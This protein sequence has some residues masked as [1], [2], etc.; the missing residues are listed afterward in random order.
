MKRILSALAAVGCLAIPTFAQNV[1][2]ARAG[3]VN[4]SEGAVTLRD[5][6]VHLT[7]KQTYIEM[8]DNEVIRTTRGRTEVLLS[9]GVTMRL[10]EESAVRLVSGSLTDTRVEVLEGDVFVEASE[11]FEGSRV[12]VALG[13]RE[14]DIAKVGLYRFNSDPA[15]IRVYDGRIELPSANPD[16]PTV[17]KKGSVVSMSNGLVARK[18]DPDEGDAFYRWASRRSGYIAMANISAAKMV[19]DDHYSSSFYGPGLLG[20]GFYGSG[21]YGT[22]LYGSGLYG[23]GIRSGWFYNPYF[24]MF[25]Y[26]PFGNSMYSPF[27]YRYYTPR[28][29]SVVYAPPPS[30]NGG[31]A[32]PSMG[33]FDRTPTYNPNY[34]YNT[35]GARSAGSSVG[36]APGPSA[37]PAAAAGGASRGGGAGMGRGSSGAGGRGK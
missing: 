31:G 10:A 22:G 35:V 11:L 12:R 7:S 4:Y 3:L 30:F 27:G 33:G 34:G 19:R 21:L 18:F 29:V 8:K 9:P 32:G 37:A 2:S 26:I 16:K 23:N 6:P 24:G 15:E 1:V 20:A 36:A 28:T 17:A 5:Q 13:G 25:T 14:A